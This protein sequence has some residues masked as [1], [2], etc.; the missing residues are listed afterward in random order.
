MN[1]RLLRLCPVGLLF[2][3]VF[4]LSGCESGG[5]RRAMDEA[6]RSVPP[7]AADE[8]FFDGQ[9]AAHLTLGSGLDHGPGQGPGKGPGGRGPR[10]GR[11]HM[12]GIRNNTSGMTEL[13]NE[14]AN[15]RPDSIDA[16]GADDNRPRYTESHMPPALLRLRLENTSAKTI[17][18]EIRDL[19]SELGNF[20]TRPDKFTLEPGASGQPGAM[21]SLL[22]LDTLALPVTLTLWVDGK[23]ETK[24]LTLRPVPV[25]APAATP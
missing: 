2:L 23:T 7:M 10:G 9:L 18:V 17:T 11:P 4:L 24:V 5:D 16:G 22:G 8:V 25:P 19:N 12:E 6:R 1:P 13:G 14:G 3:G 15:E 21:Q 20:A